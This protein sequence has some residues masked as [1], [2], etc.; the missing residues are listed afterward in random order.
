MKT[1]GFVILSL[2]SCSAFAEVA[3]KVQS[4]PSMWIVGLTLAA[5]LG[6]LTYFKPPFLV[7]AIAVSLFLGYGYYDLASDPALRQLILEEKGNSY[8]LSGYISSSLILVTALSA[9]CLK[10]FRNRGVRTNFHFYGT[11]S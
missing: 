3:D 5:V 11:A 2:F 8:F 1:H 4:Y 6:A 7:L 9:A 10:L